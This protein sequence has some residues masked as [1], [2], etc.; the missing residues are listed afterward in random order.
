MS[1]SSDS[2]AGMKVSVLVTTYNGAAFVIQQLESIRLQSRPVDEVLIFDDRSTDDTPALVRAFVGEHGLDG[3]HLEVNGRNL[4]PS[5]NTLAH[6]ERITGD[7]VFFADQDDEWHPD[8]VRQMLERLEPATEC[9]LVASKGVSISGSGREYARQ[10]EWSRR[11]EVGKRGRAAP[12]TQFELG[13][14]MVHTDIPLHSLL[15]RRQVVDL[16]LRVGWPPHL[17]R[18]VGVDWYLEAV[19]CLRG[20]CVILDAPLVRRRVHD[21][22]YSLQGRRK[23]T[24]LSISRE[25]R[26]SM[27]AHTRDAHAFVLW[28]MQFESTPQ[29]RATLRRA[30]AFLERR[31]GAIEHPTPIGFL[32][33]LAWAN[34]YR[35]TSGGVLQGA[36][37]WLSDVL[38]GFE[39]NP[40]L[41][42]RRWTCR[43]SA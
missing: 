32:R 23:V 28:A 26:L 34:L 25:A 22:N 15:L 43:T 13:D 9:V 1:G 3:W 19:S 16:I 11:R 29:Q 6:L 4:G 42:L 18:S 41:P 17:S 33:L 38:Y 7:V 20:T 27:L 30:I 36:R 40:R 2:M 31:S 12:E 14:V 37:A 24:T 39:I 8:K 5:E 10:P 21:S 35:A